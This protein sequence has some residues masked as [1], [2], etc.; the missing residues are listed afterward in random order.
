M[1]VNTEADTNDITACSHSDQP[2]IGMF[3]CL[4]L[5]S[6][7]SSLFS[8]SLFLLLLPFAEFWNWLIFNELCSFR[9]L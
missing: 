5:H 8:L 4:M 6:L 2:T 9:L 1:E 3:T 7:Q